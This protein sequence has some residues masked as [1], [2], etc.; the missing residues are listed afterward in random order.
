LGGRALF[1]E[2]SAQLLPGSEAVLTYV[3]DWLRGFKNRVEITGHA[4]PGEAAVSGA[5]KDEWELAWA[6]AR[7][8]ADFLIYTCNIPANRLKLASAG[9]TDPASVTLFPDE[10]TRFRRVE[11][12]VTGEFIR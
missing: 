4:A 1:Q 3:A 9:S 7:S 6:R 11:V 8:V 10:A 5:Y 12:V 2:G